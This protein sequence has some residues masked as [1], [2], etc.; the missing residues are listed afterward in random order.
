MDF[1][2]LVD[3]RARY[4]TYTYRLLLYCTAKFVI[5]TIHARGIYLMSLLPILKFHIIKRPSIV[6]NAIY[7][8]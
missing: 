6:R 7:R 2:N 3:P 4:L 5:A 8:R 1:K